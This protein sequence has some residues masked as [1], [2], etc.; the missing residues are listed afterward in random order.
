MLGGADEGLSS[1]FYVL[2]RANLIWGQLVAG[3]L[4]I[5]SFGLFEPPAVGRPGGGKRFVIVSRL[6]VA[7]LLLAQAH[8]TWLLE[9]FKT[10]FV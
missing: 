7:L 8:N 3:E 9:I 6:S 5:S 1:S 2:G 10:C 4:H